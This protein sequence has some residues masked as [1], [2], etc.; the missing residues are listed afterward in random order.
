MQI[1][2]LLQRIKHIIGLR[3]PARISYHYLRGRAAF[4]LSGNPVKDMYIIGV[5]GTKGKTTTSTLI[6]RALEESGRKVAL[7]ST[8]QIWIAGEK[9]ENQSKMTMDNPFDMWKTLQEARTKGVTHLVLETSSHGIYYFRNFGIRY[10]AVV[11][12]NISQDHLDLHGTMDHYASTKA[13]IF[14][15]EPE[16]ICVLPKDCEY[17]SLFQNAARAGGDMRNIITYSIKEPADYRLRALRNTEKGMDIDIKWPDE[18]TM[19]QTQL[20]GVFNAENILAA[21]SLLRSIGVTNAHIIRAWADFTGVHGRLEPVPN[22]LWFT[23]LVDY[24]HTETSLR[25]VLQT[26]QT[27]GKMI[28]VFGATGDRDTTKR[29]KMGAVADEYADIIVLTDDDTYS[30][31]SEKIITMVQEGIHRMPG[32][33]YQ[34]IPDRREAIRWALKHAQTGDTVLIAGKGCETVLVTNQWAIPWSDRWVV[35]EILSTL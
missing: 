11:L 30:E 13:R 19:I 9:R 20:K 3:N 31:S 22:K 21:Y 33:T 2:K 14:Q 32:D 27:D 25:S 35:E 10:N 15:K 16:K 29:P 4:M 26:L 12:T 8:A 1:M 18:E 17:F 34:M 5:T 24:A 7:L 6:A 23:I 28:L